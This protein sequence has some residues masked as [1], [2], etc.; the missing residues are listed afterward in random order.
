MNL[1]IADTPETRELGLMFRENLEE[2]K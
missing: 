2:N 1:E